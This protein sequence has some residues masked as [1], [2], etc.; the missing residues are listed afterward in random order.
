M[1][2]LCLCICEVLRRRAKEEKREGG[3][4]VMRAF[5]EEECQAGFYRLFG[6]LVYPTNMAAMFGMVCVR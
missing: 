6:G 2:V 4:W 5:E 1:E 3:N